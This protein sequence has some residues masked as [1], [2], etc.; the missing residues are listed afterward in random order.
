M[1]KLR[2]ILLSSLAV[3]AVSAVAA[4]TAS[5]LEFYNSS[6]ELV[7]GLLK[8]EGTGGESEI[9]TELAGTQI[10]TRCST[11]HGTGW[12]RNE[13]VG[14]ELAGLGLL[15]GTALGCE[16]VQPAGTGCVVRGGIVI[17]AR[18]KLVTISG[19]DY[20]E[21]TPA[22]GTVFFELILEDCTPSSLD[23]TYPV[24]G[25]A[26]ALVNNVTSEFEFM[27]G[28]PNNKLKFAGNPVEFTGK[29]T[30]LMEDGGGILVKP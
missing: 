9:I 21:L 10:K 25:T 8:M 17:H 13:R 14:E 22:E 30:V 3:F 26:Y 19:K 4:G 16:I 18:A 6:G 28:A 27:T 12:I 29:G 20:A 24:K 1:S 2:L 23:G 7:K 15:V 11:E 5:A